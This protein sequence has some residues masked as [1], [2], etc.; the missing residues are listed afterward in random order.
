MYKIRGNDE[1]EYGPV[2]AEVVRH[3]VNEGR[4]NGRTLVQ[5]SG[6]TEWRP[7]NSVVELALALPM[8][9]PV[10]A[11]PASSVPPSNSGLNKVIPYRNIPALAGYYCAVFAL[12]PFVGILL[13]LLAMSLGIAGLRVA[14]R[15]PAAG[16]KIHAWVGIVLGLLC[17]TG[18]LALALAIFSAN[19]PYRY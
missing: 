13:G 3:W 7:L 4:A 5:A 8:P 9:P 15:N 18:Y 12:I 19:R 1:R 6:S 2:P 16:G 11:E 14:R 10:P 17:A